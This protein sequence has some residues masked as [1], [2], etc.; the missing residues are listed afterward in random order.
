[1][2]KYFLIFLG[3]YIVFT[4]GA[5]SVNRLFPLDGRIVGGKNTNIKEHPY[6]VSLLKYGSH[7]CGGSILNTGN[8]KTDGFFVITAAHCVIPYT[9]QN[10]AVKFGITSLNQLSPIA[11]VDVIIRHEN[12]NPFTSDY[13]IAL[14]KLRNQIPFS[15]SSQ[16]I[17]MS[18]INPA[19]GT[20]AVVTGWGSTSE[21]GL[22]SPTLQAVTVKVV[23]SIE[24]ATAYAPYYGI[25]TERM[26][27]AAVPQG[28][29]DSCQGDSGGPL[30][31]DGVQ[32]GIVSWG[33]GCARPGFPGVYS[34]V[35]S[36]FSWI[37]KN[38]MILE[39]L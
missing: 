16:P 4:N 22:L 7:T 27:C 30:V 11:L 3:F 17:R 15:N 20:A 6:Q 34:R 33:L 9:P 25:I 8:N 5:T 29:K 28:G 10:Y 39:A 21:G 19:D 26:L 31:A 18:S 1:M 36:L 13:D 12:Y 24:C 32:I 2:C 14:I 35:P 23:D 37:Q 38:V